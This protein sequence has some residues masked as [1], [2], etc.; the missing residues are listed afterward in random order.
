MNRT[1]IEQ[2]LVEIIVKQLDVPPEKVTREAGFATDLA[3]DSLEIAE[4]MM[5]MEDTFDLAVPEGDADEIRTVGE[6]ID[7]VANHT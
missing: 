1:E 6:A 4:L 5:Q 7:Y 3:M 2:K